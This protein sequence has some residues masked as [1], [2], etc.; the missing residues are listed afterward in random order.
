MILHIPHSSQTIPAPYQTLFLKDVSLREELLA[1]TD[2]YTDLLFDYP[3]LKLVF[4]VSRLLCDTERFYDPKDEPMSAKG[5]WICYENTSR[6]TPLKTLTQSHIDEMLTRYY[7]PHHQTL[8]SLTEQELARQKRALIV[9]CHSFSS[10]PLPY[11]EDQTVPR[12]DFCLGTDDMHT[13]PALI[14]ACKAFLT[15]QG[16]HVTVNKP[17]QGTMVPVAYLNKNRRGHSI[18]IEVNR[19]FYCNESDGSMLPA[20]QKIKHH[21]FLLLQLL[22]QSDFSSSL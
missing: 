9:D 20:F 4:P 10:T 16:Y 22:E 6:G 14:Q 21:L 13:P 7:L 11:E 15:A 5:M 18:M 12:A 8:T 17:Y 3:C 1:M 19:K 2:L